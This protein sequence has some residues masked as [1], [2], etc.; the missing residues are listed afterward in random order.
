[1]SGFL[2]SNASEGVIPP[3]DEVGVWLIQCAVVCMASPQNAAGQSWSF[4][5]ACIH[6]V[7]ILFAHS[8]T[9][10]CCGVCGMVSSSSMPVAAQYSCSHWLT[11]SPPLSMHRVLTCWPCWFANKVLSLINQFMKSLLCFMGFTHIFPDMSSMIVMKYRFPPSVGCSNSL[12][13][14][15]CTQ[16][17][18][19]PDWKGDDVILAHT[20]ASQVTSL[21]SSRSWSTMPLTTPFLSFFAGLWHWGVLD[22]GGSDQGRHGQV[23]EQ[24]LPSHHWDSCIGCA[25]CRDCPHPLTWQPHPP[26]GLTR[27][28]PHP[29]S[30]LQN[31][32]S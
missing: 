7:S 15:E 29:W 2:P 22:I 23:C 19:W 8:V 4:I 17:Q 5:M 28:Q 3:L 24:Y 20:Y 26:W 9:P 13:R 32:V 12:H 16:A 14:S 6:S 1:M 21:F 18:Q 25:G 30:G 31:H 11:Y 10:F 27:I